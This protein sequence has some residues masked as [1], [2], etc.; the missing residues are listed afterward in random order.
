MPTPIRTLLAAAD[1]ISGFH[2]DGV[3]QDD[4]DDLLSRLTVRDVIH[5]AVWWRRCMAT[6][7]HT[8][9]TEILALLRRG[10][11]ITQQLGDDLPSEVMAMRDALGW[12]LCRAA[13]LR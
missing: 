9:A 6:R 1:H 13:G 7:P 5:V 11:Q 2:T 8:P 10:E 4:L 3:T 12:D